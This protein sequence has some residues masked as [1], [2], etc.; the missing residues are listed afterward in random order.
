LLRQA[1]AAIIS[2]DFYIL[3]NSNLCLAFLFVCLVVYQ[4]PEKCESPSQWSAN[5]RRLD[6]S[7]AFLQYGNF[8]YDSHRNR[9]AE[10]HFSP[11]DPTSQRWVINL[12]DVQPPTQYVV[13]TSTPTWTCT[14]QEITRPWHPFG[15]PPDEFFGTYEYVGCSGIEYA[16]V[17]TAVWTEHD[18]DG[19]YYTTVTSRA[20]IPISQVHIDN[21]TSPWDVRQANYYNV[22]IGNSDPNVFSPP[23]Q[24]G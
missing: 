13:N 19:S 22:V 6:Q 8:W 9:T 24:C 23:P 18:S 11:G 15:I 17:L 4:T 2:T 7:Q 10:Q 16:N 14:K 5:F 21:T 3:N 1:A 20:C 12:W